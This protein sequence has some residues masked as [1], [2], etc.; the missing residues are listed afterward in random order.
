MHHAAVKST[1][2]GLPAATASFMRAREKRSQPSK[3]TPAAGPPEADAAVAGPS[4]SLS[5]AAKASSTA[6]A[7]RPRRTQVAAD[8][9]LPSFS[10]QIAKAIR[11]M[12]PSA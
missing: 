2:T 6:M 12:P 11:I 1:N 4:S 9:P 10:S 8:A 5:A 7:A 3:F